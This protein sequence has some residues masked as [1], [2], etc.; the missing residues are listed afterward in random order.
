MV[1]TEA[2][3]LSSHNTAE[4]GLLDIVTSTVEGLDICPGESVTGS[5][6]PRYAFKLVRGHLENVATLDTGSNGAITISHRDVTVTVG[7]QMLNSRT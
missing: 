5:D 7:E 4:S 1:L 3:I 6:G 2:E